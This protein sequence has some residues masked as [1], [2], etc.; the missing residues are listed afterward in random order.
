MELCKSYKSSCPILAIVDISR[1][2]KASLFDL[3]ITDYISFPIVDAEFKVRIKQAIF[4]CH[5]LNMG[6]NEVV[7]ERYNKQIEF[8]VD[9]DSQAI[10]AKIKSL[11]KKTII[12][13]K[14]N[15]SE[16][17]TL[18]VLSSE[19]AVNRNKLSESFKAY[20]GFT[21][22]NWQREQRMASAAQMLLSTSLTIQQISNKV[23]YSDSNNFSTAFKRIYQTSPREYRRM[24]HT[25]KKVQ[26]AKE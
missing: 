14:E 7:L 9:S 22:F 4:L 20:T 24:Q 25:K 10:D 13:L 18:E 19:M 5:Y 21:I 16:E 6:L 23:G 15:I 3:G 8:K 2:D 26:Q 11:A 17:I 1:V 12:Y